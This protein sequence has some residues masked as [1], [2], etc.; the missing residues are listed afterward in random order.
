MLQELWM[1]FRE[2]ENRRRELVYLYIASLISKNRISEIQSCYLS[3]MREGYSHLEISI[4]STTVSKEFIAMRLPNRVT[5][6]IA[7]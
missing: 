5:F 7:L 1:I 2:Y 3:A 6:P 4:R